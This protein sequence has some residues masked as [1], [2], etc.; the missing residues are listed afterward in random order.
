MCIVMGSLHIKFF[1]NN[2]LG[3]ERCLG[4]PHFKAFLKVSYFFA[5]SEIF[6]GRTGGR[7]SAASKRYGVTLWSCG[8]FWKFVSRKKIGPVRQ[9]YKRCGTGRIEFRV[10]LLK[11]IAG[12]L[13]LGTT[14]FRPVQLRFL[15]RPVDPG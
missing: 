6:P 1:H 12:L 2:S 4:T 11:G 10:C 13:R 3:A 8:W 15:H 14:F 7:M 5:F 9:A